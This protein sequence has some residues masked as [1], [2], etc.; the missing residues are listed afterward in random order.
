VT[1]DFSHDGVPHVVSRD[2]ALGLFR[3]LQE[4][5]DNAV[6]HSKARNLAVE[7][8]GRSRPGGEEIELLVSDNGIGFDPEGVIRGRGLG[9][10]HM[11]ERLDLV[12]GELLVKSWPGAGT[13][14]TARVPVAADSSIEP[15][16][17]L[18]T[19]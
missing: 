19:L 2:A 9:L 17:Q 10:I 7:L 13:T 6:R 3:V 4:A 16:S 14:I 12:H 18:D 1:I 11:R 5:L 15:S 8:R